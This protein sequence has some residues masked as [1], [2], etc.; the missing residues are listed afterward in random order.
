MRR[1]RF[2]D[3]CY[4]LDLCNAQ[5]SYL[6]YWLR[7]MAQMPID[8]PSTDDLILVVYGLQLTFPPNQVRFPDEDNVF[9]V[10]TNTLGEA[11]SSQG[12]DEPRRTE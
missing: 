10:I 3:W 9:V 4:V 5:L 2:G 12:L 1:S 7:S 8:L 6:H 11:W